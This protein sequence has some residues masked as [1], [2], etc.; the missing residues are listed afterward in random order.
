MSL[1]KSTSTEIT[2]KVWLHKRVVVF[3][4]LILIFSYLSFSIISNFK[5]SVYS[6]FLDKLQL[7]Q[8]WFNLNNNS[9]ETIIYKNRWLLGILISIK[10]YSTFKAISLIIFAEIELTSVF[11]HFQI[12]VNINYVSSSEYLACRK[13][14]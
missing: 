11:F 7:Y 9:N 10:H 1:F 5:L 2:S 3:R 14:T 8:P 13:N 6:S 4:I 12:S